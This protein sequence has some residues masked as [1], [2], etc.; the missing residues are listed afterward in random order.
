MEDM[1]TIEEEVKNTHKQ[2]LTEINNLKIVNEMVLIRKNE[3]QKARTQI[4]SFYCEIYLIRSV[5]RSNYVKIYAS[6]SIP[7]LSMKLMNVLR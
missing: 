1:K 6:L 5:Y 4:L 2:Y 3:L 7:N